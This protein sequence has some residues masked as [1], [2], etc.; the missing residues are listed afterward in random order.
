[1]TTPFFFQNLHN[2]QKIS[3]SNNK[4][5]SFMDDFL[6]SNGDIHWLIMGCDVK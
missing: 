1:M 6:K 5:E 3:N 4:T 2:L